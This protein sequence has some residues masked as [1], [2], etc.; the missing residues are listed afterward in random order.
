MLKEDNRGCQHKCLWLYLTHFTIFLV[1]YWYDRWKN[2]VGRC[3][4][5]P[6]KVV[7]I[8]FLNSFVKVVRIRV[9][10]IVSCVQKFCWIENK[11]ICARTDL[12]V[13]CG[14]LI[15][16]S[17]FIFMF[18]LSSELLTLWNTWKQRGFLVHCIHVTDKTHLDYTRKGNCC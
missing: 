15:P 6:W 7:S 3:L 4:W 1:L 8:L 14:L 10:C 17:S 2:E 5:S 11:W 13:K 12:R 18:M 16:I 9:H